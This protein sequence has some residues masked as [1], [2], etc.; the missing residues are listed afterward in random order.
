M[1]RLDRR[2]VAVAAGTLALATL[3][4]ATWIPVPD[5][6]W[7]MVKKP[8]PELWPADELLVTLGNTPAVAD[9]PQYWKRNTLL[10]DLAGVNGSGS[11]VLQ[12]RTDKQWPVRIAVRVMPGQVGTLEVRA[13]Q[14]R[15]LL[16][17]TPDGVKPVDLELV[18]GMY[19]PKTS[20][21]RVT[22]GPPSVP[23]G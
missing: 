17:I 14:Q 6:R 4:G 21:I 11:V 10:L 9:F 3:T 18:P 7:M 8:A 22:W 20:Q 2:I 19:T 15:L 13:E 1:R 12:P 16:P 23:V 5:F